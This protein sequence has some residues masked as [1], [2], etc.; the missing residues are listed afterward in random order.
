MSETINTIIEFES[1]KYK[2]VD[3][4]TAL[5]IFTESVEQCKQAKKRKKLDCAAMAFVHACLVLN[6]C[7][8]TGA[9]ALEVVNNLFTDLGTDKNTLEKAINKIMKK[10]RKEYEKNHTN[11]TWL[12]LIR[13]RKRKTR[14]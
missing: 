6:I 14:L 8:L 10:E 4:S 12:G 1:K 7:Y 5:D 13:V 3:F 9:Q 2:D 11:R